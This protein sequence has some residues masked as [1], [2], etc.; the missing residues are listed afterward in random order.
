MI[1]RRPT[2]HDQEDK[3]DWS[4]RTEA[5]ERCWQGACAAGRHWSGLSHGELRGLRP[6][7]RGVNYLIAR[8]DGL[9]GLVNVAAIRST[10][11]S[12]SLG[13]GEHVV[14]PRRRAGRRARTR[15]WPLAPARPAAGDRAWWRRTAL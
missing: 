9:P 3:S 5:R 13:I 14:T 4:V 8:V 7:G 1:D 11:L 12:A 2:A 6:A 10:G 15:S